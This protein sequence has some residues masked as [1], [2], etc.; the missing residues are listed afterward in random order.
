MSSEVGASS[1][2]YLKKK[3]II[4]LTASATLYIYLAKT[5]KVLSSGV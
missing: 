2:F 1:L 5:L 4:D 3:L